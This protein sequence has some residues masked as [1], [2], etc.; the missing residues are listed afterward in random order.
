MVWPDSE[1][2]ELSQIGLVHG[3]KVPLLPRGRKYVHPLTSVDGFKGYC[4]L[5]GLVLLFHC[6]LPPFA[7]RPLHS[8]SIGGWLVVHN[9]ECVIDE[10]VRIVNG[11]LVIMNDVLENLP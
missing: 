4:S 9:H 1:L 7:I 5:K 8:F 10:D 6:G 11:D 3:N 2:S